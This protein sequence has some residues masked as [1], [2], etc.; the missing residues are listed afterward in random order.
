MVTHCKQFPSQ[1]GFTVSEL[2]MALALGTILTSMAVPAF[3]TMID[4]NRL[5]SSVYQLVRHL[6][7]A[8]STAITKARE[9]NICKSQDG[10]DCDNEVE[11]EEGWIV[12]EDTSSNHVRDPGEPLLLAQKGLNGM[13]TI[14]Y[15]GGLGIDNYVVFKPTG[16]T[17]FNGTFTFCSGNDDIA[18]RAIIIKRGRARISRVQA[19]GSPINCPE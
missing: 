1:S 13:L 2:M 4:G 18:P 9:I 12:Y 15:N 14:D 10:M 19:D 8:R 11:W 7:Y 5:I 6:N 17:S 16:I 3:N